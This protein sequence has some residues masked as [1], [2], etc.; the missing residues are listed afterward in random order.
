MPLDEI[1]PGVRPVLGHQPG[2]RR[3]V[4][5]PVVGAQ[6]I[7]LGPVAADDAHDPIGHL[8]LDLVEKPRLGRVE[9][10]VEVEDPGG[11]VGKTVADHASLLLRP[12][13]ARTREMAGLLD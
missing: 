1:S 7:S 9:R 4:A 8:D 12:V 13:V 11:H 10:V 5:L 2:Q 6:P 3:A